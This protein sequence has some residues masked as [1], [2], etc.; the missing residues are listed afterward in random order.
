[1]YIDKG[2]IDFPNV[3]LILAFNTLIAFTTFCRNWRLR[4]GQFQSG[5][6]FCSCDANTTA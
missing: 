1:M 2:N 6:F 3:D 4:A 5:A